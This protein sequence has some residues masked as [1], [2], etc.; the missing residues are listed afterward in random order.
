N[1]T[2]PRFPNGLGND[3]GV[4]GKYV[5][6]HNYRVEGHGRIDGFEDTYF[7]GRNPTECI[8]VNFRNLGKQDTD[9]VGGYTTFTGAYRETGLE[10]PEDLGAA[11]KDAQSQPGPLGIYM[12]MQGETI[13]KESNHVRLHESRKDQ[14]G[15]PLLVMNVDYDDNDA[16]MIRDWRTQAE[17]MLAVAGCRDI[18]THDKG[19]CTG[20]RTP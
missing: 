17:E 14:W 9:F 11:Y 18:E 1:S 3:H 7:F 13:P 15:I 19:S 6:H 20:V 10:T 4:L 12:Y 8:L 16:R 2:S 5:C